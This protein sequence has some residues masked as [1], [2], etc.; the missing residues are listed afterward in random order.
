MSAVT[1]PKSAAF[2]ISM[3]LSSQEVTLEEIQFENFLSM[4]PGIVGGFVGSVIHWPRDLK[5]LS[6]VS[7]TL[8]GTWDGK[9]FLDLSSSYDP[10]FAQSPPKK[11]G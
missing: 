4:I 7:I 5:G 8:R 10:T 6:G 2:E 1:A 3:K 9:K 11:S